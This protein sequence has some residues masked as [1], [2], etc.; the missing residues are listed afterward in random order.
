MGNL[1]DKWQTLWRKPEP[2]PTI[3]RMRVERERSAIGK[4]NDRLEV[5][6][7][8]TVPE[9]AVRAMQVALDELLTNVVMHARQ[10]AGSI[11]L[12]IA[13]SRRA[14][15]VRISYIAAEFDPTRTPVT[16]VTTVAA[17]PIGG[18]G[19]HLVRSLMDEFRYEYLDGLNVLHLRKKC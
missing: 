4:L 1:R 19:I 9:Q 17:S 10:A 11:E 5:T 14:L 12:E 8:P 6:L 2:A 7:L 15:D 16:D 13:H 3:W 18:L